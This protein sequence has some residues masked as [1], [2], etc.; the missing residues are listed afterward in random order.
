MGVVR[1]TSECR[2]LGLMRHRECSRRLPTRSCGAK[3]NGEALYGTV[4]GV[5]LIRSRVLWSCVLSVARRTALGK[6]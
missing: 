4:I 6:P 5:D 2:S 3:G 1:G